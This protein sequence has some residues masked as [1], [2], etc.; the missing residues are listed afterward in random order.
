MLG[1]QWISKLLGENKQ[2]ALV[3]N[4]EATK[5]IIYKSQW[6]EYAT[7]KHHCVYIQQKIIIH[8]SVATLKERNRI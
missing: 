8:S 7:E 5:P 4:R 3:I 1:E 6:K 2:S